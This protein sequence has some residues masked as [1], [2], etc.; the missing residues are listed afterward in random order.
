VNIGRRV[1]AVD[2]STI[3]HDMIMTDDYRVDIKQQAELFFVILSL[4]LVVT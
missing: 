3:A 4:I 2:L 1:V